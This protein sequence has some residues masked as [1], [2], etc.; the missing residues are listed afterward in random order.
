MRVLILSVTAG[1]GH[2]SCSAALREVLERRGHEVR[3]ADLYRACGVPRRLTDRIYCACAKNLRT[4][5]SR[6]YA[7]LE[8]D[9]ALRRRWEKRFLPDWIYP[10]LRSF[11]RE[12]Q[13]DCV[14][15]MH[16]FAARALSVLG[17][18]GLIRVPVLGVNTD[19]CLHP[20]WEDCSG[21]EGLV[22]PAEE[23]TGEALDRGIPREI[24]LPLGIPI[25]SPERYRMSR[26]EARSGL[27]LGPGKLILLMGGSMGYGHMFSTALALRR[28]AVT[29]VCI[30]GK[31][32]LLR[33][34]LRPFRNE[35]LLVLGFIRDLPEYMRSAD[36]AVTKPGG[37]SLAELAAAGVPVLLT[38]P[39]PGHEER[40]LRFWTGLGAAA[41]G[42]KCRT[43]GETAAL[44]LALLEDGDARERMQTAQAALGRPLAA[45]NL[46]SFVEGL[47]KVPEHG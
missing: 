14:V 6:T 16:V 7:R 4:R 13:P 15:A 42:E 21:L 29:T 24:L 47:D 19:F 26:E 28:E 25:R 44:A 32:R 43:G 10:R 20:Y 18:Q 9:E 2:N 27:G 8:R 22:I 5:Y 41:S 34:F 11:L 37:L 40:N 35:R 33:F 39:I 31:N 46:C 12:Q 23:M 38:L 1:E 3:A 36:L 30:C 45:E 17:K